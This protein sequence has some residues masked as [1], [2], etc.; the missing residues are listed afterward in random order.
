MTAR[1]GLVAEKAVADDQPL[2]IAEHDSHGARA[3]VPAGRVEDAVAQDGSVYADHE[4][5]GRRVVHVVVV[6]VDAIDDRVVAAHEIPEHCVSQSRST[7]SLAVVACRASCA[8]VAFR[9]ATAAIR[10]CQ[11]VE[12]PR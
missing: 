10:G 5:M 4:R 2:R 12:G 7:R 8:S 3:G 1:V 9:P 11:P 6:A